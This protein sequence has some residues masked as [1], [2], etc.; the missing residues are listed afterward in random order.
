M[1]KKLKSLLGYRHDSPFKDEPYIDIQSN[2][3]DMSQ[4]DK[5]LILIP[6]KGKPVIAKARSGG[7]LFPN[8]SKV[9]EIPLYQQGGQ[10][11][12]NQIKKFDKEKLKA[13]Q[14]DL[15]SKGLYKGK[16]DGVYGKLTQQAIDSHNKK[17]FTQSDYQLSVTD[18]YGRE[19]TAPGEKEKYL[20]PPKK[21]LK[22]ENSLL[23]FVYNNLELLDNPITRPL[24]QRQL[25]EKMKT[26]GGA[27]YVTDFN[28]KNEPD[29]Y[30]GSNEG[31][32]NL[33]KQYVYGN[34]NIPKSKYK[35]KSDYLDFLPSYSLKDS[36]IDTKE[37]YNEFLKEY[38]L[39]KFKDQ[40]FQTT[41][42][43]IGFAQKE[44]SEKI[45][46]KEPIY[47]TTK[48][49][50][51][52]SKYGYNL[53]SYK[54]GIGYD[55]NTED[56]YLS[57]S[58]AWDFE[59]THYTS[60]WGDSNP[61]YYQQ[62]YIAHKLGKP[63]K[64]YDRFYLNE[65][66]EKKYQAGGVSMKPVSP[67]MDLKMFKNRYKLEQLP[68][69]QMGGILDDYI[70]TLPEEQ[71]NVFMGEFQSLEPDVQQEVLFMLGGKYQMGGDIQKELDINNIE[72]GTFYVPDDREDILNLINQKGYAYYKL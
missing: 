72:E 8:A 24:L 15:K 27:Q 3:I 39:D 57:I 63:F 7:Y 4:T 47:M 65:M 68:T 54:V 19:V 30:T 62:A 60:K 5:D 21:K 67:F 58:D 18:D 26:S 35:P 40:N 48:M 56:P 43:A 16:I 33:V 51:I 64:I 46:N 29:N 32:Y 38:A 49:G 14:L 61:E 45:K 69:Y 6:N 31:K 37:L 2:N 59:P 11:D 10:I 42:E 23:N 22:G 50:S 17:N 20:N 41:E 34:Q 28:T 25:E 53:G 66:K 12:S 36:T 70:K 9:T 55:E 52:A 1:N 13:V 44:I 71:Q